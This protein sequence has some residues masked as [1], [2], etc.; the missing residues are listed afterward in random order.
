MAVVV[1]PTPPFWFTTATTLP[2]GFI[3]QIVPRGTWAAWF[4]VKHC[5]KPLLLL[6]AVFSSSKRRR[7]DPEVGE[8]TMCQD[9]GD[10]GKPTNFHRGGPEARNLP[11]G[12]RN[13]K[14]RG[15]MISSDPAARV[16][17][18]SNSPPNPGNCLIKASALPVRTRTSS[19]P[20]SLTTVARKEVRRRRASIKVRLYWG[21]TIFN[22]IPGIPAPDPRSRTRWMWGGRKR[23]KSNESR[24]SFS[25]ITPRSR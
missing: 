21:C 25:R 13:R 24:N 15:A 18:A 2:T 1:F 10:T 7:F 9:A 4:H 19:R 23:R 20:S 5:R 6:Q 16:R 14:A 22:G 11:P 17:T 8:V 3:L 12:L